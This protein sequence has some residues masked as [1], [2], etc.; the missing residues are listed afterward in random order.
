MTSKYALRVLVALAGDPEGD[1]VLGSELAERSD[2]PANYLS[3]ILLMLRNAGIIETIRGHGGGYRLRRPPE[4]IWL[5]EVVEVFEGVRTHP[6]CVLGIEE[7]CSDNTPCS[8]HAS[9]REVRQAYITFLEN[10]SIAD[11][12]R[13]D[14]L[15]QRRRKYASAPGTHN[16]SSRLRRTKRRESSR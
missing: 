14:G 12:A 9:F 3:K 10:T 8:A 16:A 5:I 13:T 6:S 7:D 4:D 11:A 1:F 2:I 15:P